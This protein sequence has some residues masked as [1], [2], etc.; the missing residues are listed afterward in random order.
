MARKE[1]DKFGRTITWPKG[2]SHYPIISFEEYQELS[3]KD[4]D[5]ALILIAGFIHNVSHFIDSHPGGRAMIKSYIGKDATVAFYGGIHDHNTAAHNML[6]MI[7]VGV[8]KYGGE[9]EHIK[10]RLGH[11]QT[12]TPV[13]S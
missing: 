8:C 1:L 5:R 12:P 10:K 3:K 11:V 4:S 13:S 9:V 6:A 7:R 2:N